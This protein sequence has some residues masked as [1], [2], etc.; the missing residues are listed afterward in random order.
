M[1]NGA[2]RVNS[3]LNGAIRSLMN[4]C[5]TSLVIVLIVSYI[6]GAN[7]VNGANDASICVNGADYV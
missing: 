3:N 5:W 6:N 2:C 1:S 7:D 4:G